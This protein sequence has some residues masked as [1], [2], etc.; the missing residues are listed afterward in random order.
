MIA[1]TFDQAMSSGFDIVGS[2]PSY[3][4]F[5]VVMLAVGLV[6]WGT[7]QYVQWKREGRFQAV[8]TIRQATRA[9]E[10]KE[11][12]FRSQESSERIA[13]SM[14]EAA[15]VHRESYDHFGSLLSEN[16]KN[17][18][19]AVGSLQ[20]QCNDHTAGL[21]QGQNE[22]LTHISGIQRDLGRVVD[23]KLDTR[24]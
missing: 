15:Q 22:M 7:G 18:V 23:R 11:E 8:E 10:R 14:K 3:L 21:R 1:S 19:A 17:V 24:E 6:P 12:L 2:L 5:V 13:G 9:K 20:M 4:L 16:L